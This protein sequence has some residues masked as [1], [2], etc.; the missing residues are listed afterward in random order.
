MKWE[1]GTTT[2]NWIPL[3]LYKSMAIDHASISPSSLTFIKPSALEP[4]VIPCSTCITSIN[5]PIMHAITSYPVGSRHP[6]PLKKNVTYIVFGSVE[7]VKVGFMSVKFCL[8]LQTMVYS[9]SAIRDTASPLFC[10]TVS[11]YVV[12]RRIIQTTCIPYFAHY[13]T[14]HEA[15]FFNHIMHYFIVSIFLSFWINLEK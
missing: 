2:I 8:Q 6:P 1:T 4:Y 15:L 13:C 14:F 12:T 9:V 10:N 3:H 11:V 5:F 7:F